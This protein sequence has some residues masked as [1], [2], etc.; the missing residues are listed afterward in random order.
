MRR[1]TVL[2]VILLALC[3]TNKA[4][5]F[6]RHELGVSV[7]A[8]GNPIDKQ[9]DDFTLEMCNKNGWDPSNRY[10]HIFHGRHHITL[11]LHYQYRLSKHLAIGVTTTWSSALHHYREMD[12]D[13]YIV[14]LLVP[15]LKTVGRAHMKSYLFFVAPTVEYQWYKS[16]NHLF[17]FYSKAAV[18]VAM[19]RFT[20]TPIVSDNAVSEKRSRTKLGYQFSPIGIGV[21]NDRIMG[22]LEGGYGYQ[23]I[24]KVGVRVGL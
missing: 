19:S 12:V 14:P 23:D 17:R 6:K 5:D 13:G 24:V 20:F 16:D 4:Q 18:G 1:N 10:Q 9:F 2:L 15:R 3:L 8:L 21:G 22:I 11:N 7:G